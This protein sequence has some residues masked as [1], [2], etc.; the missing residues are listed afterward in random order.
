MPRS[1]LTNKQ[2]KFVSAYVQTGNSAKAAEVAYDIGGQG[3]SST[4][5]L[6]KFTAAAIGSQNL[7]K[8]LVKKT[9][10]DLL[11][12]DKALW[13]ENVMAELKKLVYCTD[14]RTKLNA[15]ELVVKIAGWMAPSRAEHTLMA[16][17]FMQQK[18]EIEQTDSKKLKD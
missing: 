6:K 14:K 1:E 18:K 4:K 12:G 15:I 3:G 5:R 2:K 7:Q 13:P 17:P 8:P 10:D 9:I 11:N 16:L